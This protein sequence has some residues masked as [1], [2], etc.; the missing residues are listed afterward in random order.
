MELECP[1]CGAPIEL[2]EDEIEIGEQIECPECGALLEVKRRGK[3]IYLEPVEEEEWEEE[4]SEE[5]EWEEE[6]EY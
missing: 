5:E 2:D 3:R 6:E 4:E 1:V